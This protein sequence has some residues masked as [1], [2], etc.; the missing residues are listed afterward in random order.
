MTRTQEG[1]VFQAI[2][3]A[4]VTMIAKTVQ[5]NNLTYVVRVKTFQISMYKI[6]II[7]CDQNSALGTETR[8]E[9]RYRYRS[10]NFSAETE[11]ACRGWSP[12]FAT[13][14]NVI[15]DIDQKIYE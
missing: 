9:F 5:M 6:F 1:N 3:C 11:I 10:H 15:I 14:L 8:V 13:G 7:V 12:K 2:I 4:M